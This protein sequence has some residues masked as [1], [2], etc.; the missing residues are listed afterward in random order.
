MK[1]KVLK[2]INIKSVVTY[3]IC[4]VLLGVILTY[5]PLSTLVGL[6]IAIVGFSLIGVNG[7]HLYN[8]FRL[9]KETTNQTLINVVGVLLGFVLIMVRHNIVSLLVAVYLMAFPIVDVIKSKG[10]KQVI[11]ENLRLD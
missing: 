7:Y 1:T 6:L 4:G 5:V 11:L 8:E 10:N 9:R 3:A 2:A